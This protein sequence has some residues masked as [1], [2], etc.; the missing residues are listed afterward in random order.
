MK[1][2]Y[3]EGST[4]AMNWQAGFE[5]QSETECP[6]EKDD[7]DSKD[8]YNAWMKGYRANRK[9]PNNINNNKKEETN[10][11]FNSLESLDTNKLEQ[12][13]KRRKKTELE[14]LLK[15]KEELDKKIFKLQVLFGE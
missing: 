15:Q 6:Y 7:S 4:N 14:K 13:L 3:K 12:E 5:A 2:P 8:Y 9:R 10:E 1:N 11:T